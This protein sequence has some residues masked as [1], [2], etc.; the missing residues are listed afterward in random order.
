M[1][2]VFQ[3]PPYVTIIS[4]VQ[5]NSTKMNMKAFVQQYQKWME[6]PILIRIML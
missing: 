6:Y 3:F 4:I 1:E 2:R 5:A